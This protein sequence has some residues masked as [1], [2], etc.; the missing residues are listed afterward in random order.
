[1]PGGVL[2]CRSVTER[3]TTLRADGVLLLAIARKVREMQKRPVPDRQ[4]GGSC[5]SSG[6]AP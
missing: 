4:V 1:M 6:V 2:V 3:V 5:A